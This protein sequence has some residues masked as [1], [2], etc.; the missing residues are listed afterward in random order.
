MKKIIALVLVTL[1]TLSFVACNKTAE[2]ETQDQ[3]LSGVFQV[4]FGRCDISPEESVPL[5]GRGG[6][7]GGMWAQDI[8]EELMISCIAVKDVENEIVLLLSIDALHSQADDYADALKQN[9]CNSTGVPV[10][11]ISLTATHTHAGVDMTKAVYYDSVMRYN[12][13]VIEQGVEVARQAIADLAPATVSVGST[14]TENLSFVRHYI[15]AD[16]SYAGD[17]FGTW[18][19]SDPVART[20]E[21]DPTMYLV[22]FERENEKDVVLCNWRAHPNY[23]ISGYS[24]SADYVGTFREAFEQQYDGLFVY[25]QGA[26]GDVN[27]STR[28]PAE[29]R[30][31]DQ[32]EAGVMLADYALDCIEKNMQP[33]DVEDITY[34]CYNYVGNI[35]HTEDSKLIDAKIV[36]SYRDTLKEYALVKPYAEQ[37]GLQSMYHASGIIERA[38][39][40]AT[41]EIPLSVMTLG[42]D[43]AIVFHSGEMFHQIAEQLE[44]DS[45]YATTLWFSYSN[46]SEGYFPSELAW[47]YRCY[48]TD[49]GL[50]EPGTSEAIGAFFLQQLEQ[51]KERETK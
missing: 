49:I 46:G 15:Q 37:Y 25:Y 33:I 22:R 38:A 4:G 9:I 28:I 29:K 35:N 39:M 2:P 21:N 42:E 27:A 50:F 44:E 45:P 23:T 36:Q 51:I 43:L 40:G 19:D 6:T 24:I 1:L 32:Y 47:E 48:E 10:D 16:G 17:G 30:A 18:L 8:S 34:T 41:D 7:T 13:M 3:G 11:H 14:E 31:A 20:C 26:A 12:T 5:S